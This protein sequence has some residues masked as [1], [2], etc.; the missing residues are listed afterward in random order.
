MSL[1]IDNIIISQQN[2]PLGTK[3]LA[4]DW[5]FNNIYGHSSTSY[6]YISLQAIVP[7]ISDIDNFTKI[8]AKYVIDY[9]TE[10]AA[11]MDVQLYNYTNLEIIPNS[12]TSLPNQTWGHG[13]SSWIDITSY[14]GKSIRIGT[15]RVGG[16][17]ANNVKL[18]SGT[19]LLKYS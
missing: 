15:K 14:A 6:A 7:K 1:E 9:E 2:I 4:V 18:E 19:L 3:V 11:T 13:A 16:V 5:G 8:E 12:E 10:G 17:G